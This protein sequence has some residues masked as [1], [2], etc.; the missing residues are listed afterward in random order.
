MSNTNYIIVGVLLMSMIILLYWYV[1]TQNIEIEMLPDE[2]LISTD[3]TDSTSE[4]Q[5]PNPASVYCVTNMQGEIQ[6]ID[7]EA[8]QVGVCHLPDGRWCD[9][10]EL[11]R[12]GNCLLPDGVIEADLYGKG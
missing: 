11:F 2:L 5:L 10:W 1:S 9:E 4:S 8:G 3:V 7:T 6:I 12:T